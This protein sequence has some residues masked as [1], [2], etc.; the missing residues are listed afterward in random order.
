MI[1]FL[2]RF[3]ASTIKMFYLT[4]ALMLLVGGS[5]NFIQ[6]SIIHGQSNDECAWKQ[7]RSRDSVA[8]ITN[9]KKGGV[10]DQAGLMN[11]DTLMM[12]NGQRFVYRTVQ[13]LIDPLNWGDYASYTIKRGSQTLVIPVRIV[14]VFNLFTF[15]LFFTGV[16]FTLVGLL[17]VMSK[18]QGE[19]QQRFMNYCL[20]NGFIFTIGTGINIQHYHLSPLQG[21]AVV[22]IVLVI[23]IAAL[24]QQILFFSYFPKS[25]K[26][27]DEKWLR[28]SV[29]AAAFVCVCVISFGRDGI[30][31]GEW[32]DSLVLNLLV[33]L[34]SIGVF[35]FYPTGLGRLTQI[36]FSDP[37]KEHR[38]PIR[39][40]IFAFFISISSMLYFAIAVQSVPFAVF[41][42][43]ELTL[44]LVLFVS[45]PIS[46]AYS[47]FR[48]GL[49]DLGIIVERSL[50]FA[51]ATAVL[52]VLYFTV[53]SLLSSFLGGYMASA[54]GLD[55]AHG[56]NI[57]ITVSAFVVLGLAFDPVKRRTEDWV[58][59]VFYQERI[60]YQKALLELS[61]ELPGLINFEQIVETL[62]TRLMNT[63]HLDMVLIHLS[64]QRYA[65]VTRSAAYRA[66]A[67]QDLSSSQQA[68]FDSL[69]A[70][71]KVLSLGHHESEELE[72]TVRKELLYT[73]KLALALPMML[74]NEVVG[75][76]AVGKK[77]SGKG[78][79]SE[80][81][82]LLQTIA[83]QAAVACENARL[84]ET[85]I[86]KQKMEDSLAIARRIQ[87]SLLPQ[88]WP[89]V[90]GLDACG[91]SVPAEI[92]GGDFFD[93]IELSATKLVVVV[94]DV[95]GKGISAALYMSK[96]QGMMQLAANRFE[97]PREMLTY[98]NSHVY[99]SMERN[100]FV[101]M[102]LGMFDMEKKELRLC[103]CGHT[104]PL[105]VLDGEV[106]TIDARG[107]GIGLCDTDLFS[108]HLQ[109]I[110]IPLKK[111]QRFVF[112]SDGLNEAVDASNEQYG[113]DRLQ[114][115]LAKSAALHANALVREL[116]ESVDAFRRETVLFDDL[117]IV[118]VDVT[119]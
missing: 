35:T 108:R 66:S 54:F 18:P 115:H 60:N 19:L 83:S 22:I 52:A 62:R 79:S 103:R 119:E 111:S 78:Y 27:S 117:T 100:S 114:S 81:V 86:Q 2:R 72:E 96:I 82:D 39:P 89:T 26:K 45:T 47:I 10:A 118:V 61:R 67:V 112:F 9:V 92:V 87:Q 34:C 24:P 59:K 65:D 13:G 36:Y 94:G 28:I 53:V 51:I 77:M 113:D 41:L 32:A 15:S 8:L 106:S 73:D 14:K 109:E 68:L 74:K 93:L 84:H 1:A 50:I 107:L 98:L 16:L 17:T 71:P 49:M 104:K 90:Q 5:I 88:H 64:P 11:G 102:A 75:M 58:A 44:P 31:P 23:L 12:I 63:L 43:P 91:S 85:E 46:I 3:S 7:L 110:V 70:Q 20:S 95:S 76:I 42:Q 57:W 33:A 97:T 40:I 105:M 30:V 48:Y 4:L 38:K 29:Y 99:G 101:T 56:T 80:D 116:T 37:S 55:T 21:L 6:N 25:T 69:C